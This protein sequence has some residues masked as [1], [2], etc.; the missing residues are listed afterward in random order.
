MPTRV[1]SG[2]ALIVTPADIAGDHAANDPK[3]T[4]MIAAI[5]AEVD[6]PTG[7]LG[8][9]LG[10]QKLEYTTGGFPCR[11]RGIALYPLVVPGSVEVSYRDRD[12]VEQTVASE[13]YRIISD[14]YLDF[15]QSFTFPATEC[16]PDAVRIVYDAGYNGTPIADGGTGSVP[17]NAKRAVILGVQQLKAISAENLFLRSEEVEGIGTF[18]YTVSDQAGAIIQRASERLLEGLRVYS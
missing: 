3:I 2:P 9:A 10:M 4:A 7:W 1:L 14:R 18:Q 5:Q 13:N 17:E 15:R 12:G 8:R 11:Q 6:G 16:V